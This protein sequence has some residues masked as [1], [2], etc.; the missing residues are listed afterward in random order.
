[1]NRVLQ[2]RPNADALA[3]RVASALDR[4]VSLARTRQSSDGAWRST[5]DQGPAVTAQAAIAL[6]WVDQVDD[7]LAARICRWLIAQRLPDGGW[8]ATPFSPKSDLGAT[9]TCWAALVRL[10]AGDTE[11]AKRARARV[12]ADGGLDALAGRIREA[13]AAAWFAAMAGVIDGRKLPQLPIGWRRFGPLV[14]WLETRVHDGIQMMS[15]QLAAIAR[16]LSGEWGTR[17]EGSARRDADTVIELLDSYQ[18]PDGSWTGFVPIHALALAALH[19]CDRGGDRARRGIAWLRGRIREDEHGSFF[20]AY[21]PDI[22]VTGITVRALR[23]AGASADDPAVA[24]GV[25]WLLRSRSLRPIPRAM[26][27]RLGAPK[28]GGWGFGGDNPAMPDTDDTGIALL[29]LAHCPGYEG[30]E[31]ATAGALEYLM[32]MQ[33]P[34]GGFPAFTWSVASRPDGPIPMVRP[35]SL[36]GVWGALQ[37]FR[38][39]LPGLTDPSYEDLTGR[40]LRALAA[41]GFRVGRAPVDAAVAWLREMQSDRGGFWGKWVTPYLVSTADVLSGLH[42]V[43]VPES[44]PMVRAGIGFLLSRQHDDGGWGDTPEAF[45]DPTLAGTG[46][47]A[48]PTT[49]WV[50]TG[51]LPWLGVRHR[52]VRR[53]MEHLLDRQ[54]PSGDWPN[55]HHVHAYLPPDRMYILP[56]TSLMHGL[57]A[58][59]MW[60]HGRA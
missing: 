5:C 60:R 36:Q 23:L 45:V 8:P 26:Q 54:L 17:L 48:C 46:P 44:D 58:L 59:A 10:G 22:W 16:R 31:E 14:R 37:M 43:G 42:A 34:D 33:N 25:R 30:V 19:A 21:D 51:L 35:G 15:L 56:A 41:Q 40:V 47:S 29:A 27:R 55:G 9:A 1:M 28:I 39:A 32:A 49:A 38:L 53:G 12:E 50:L 7:A 11:A 24:G 2:T 52:A 18:N 3:P 6:A 4:A 13:D 20:A 57:E